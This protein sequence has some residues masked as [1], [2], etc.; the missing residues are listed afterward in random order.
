[1]KS[2]LT[3]SGVENTPYGRLWKE[4]SHAGSTFMNDIFSLA[5]V[6]LSTVLSYCE[7]EQQQQ[8]AL[9]DV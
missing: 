8:K 5:V 2:V 6:F 4:K 1:M 3:L 7:T 9:P